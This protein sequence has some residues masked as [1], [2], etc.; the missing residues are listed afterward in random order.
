MDSV[1]FFSLSVALLMV[2]IACGIGIAI[3]LSKWF[4][5]LMKDIAKFIEKKGL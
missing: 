5:N 3:G 4:D 2:C 1:M